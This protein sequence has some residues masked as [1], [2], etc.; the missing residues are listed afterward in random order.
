[1]TTANSVCRFNSFFYL[2]KGTICTALRDIE[3]IHLETLAMPADANYHLITITRTQK[4]HAVISCLEQVISTQ[5][6]NNMQS[7]SFSFFLSFFLF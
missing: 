1:M 7:H 3:Q 2:N 4:Y 5:K 6:V